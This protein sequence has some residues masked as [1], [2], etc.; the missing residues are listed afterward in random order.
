MPRIITFPRITDARGSLSFAERLPFDIKRAYWVFD[1]AAE[2][3]R[4]GHSHKTLERI[5]IPMAGSFVALVNEKPYGLYK[6]WVGLYVEP[7]EWLDLRD[8]SAGAAF[9]VLASAEYSEADYI[10][11]RADYDKLISAN[12]TR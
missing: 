5:L 12:T 11:D 10:R 1:L 8:F 4:G 9:I 2:A 3:T 6:P 7:L